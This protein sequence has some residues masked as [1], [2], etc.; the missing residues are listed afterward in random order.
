MLDGSDFPKQGRK[1]VGVARQYCGRLGKVANCQAW[2]V[3]GLRQPVGTGV[4]GQG[5]VSA[6]SWTS[7]KDRCDCGGCAGGP[8]GTT[9]W[10]GTSGLEWV[11]ADDA[12]GMSP[13]FREGLAA[14]G[15]DT[16][17]TLYGMA[18]GPLYGPVRSIWGFGPRKPK[19]RA[20]AAADHGAAR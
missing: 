18:L 14:L 6:Q 9:H 2:D 16:C 19:L 20:W 11:A 5:A 7:D 15:M 10:S 8:A 1:S 3:P 13:S 17:W 4:G 12:F